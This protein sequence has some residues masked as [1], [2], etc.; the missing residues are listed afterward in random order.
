MN[1]VNNGKVPG[2]LRLVSTVIPEK[3]TMV[4]AIG[5]DA[6]RW[7]APTPNACVVH[8]FKSPYTLQGILSPARLKRMRSSGSVCKTVFLQ[9]K[10]SNNFWLIRQMLVS[11][12]AR[13]LGGCEKLCCLT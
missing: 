8:S 10:R 6:E 9:K 3:L 2:M 7:L 13:A 4:V 11:S 12:S 5:A 1:Q